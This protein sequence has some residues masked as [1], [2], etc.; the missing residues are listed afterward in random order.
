MFAAAYLANWTPH[1]VLNMGTP[2][3]S[4]VQLHDSAIIEILLKVRA[5]TQVD[6]LVGEETPGA[7]AESVG[8]QQQSPMDDSGG[9]QPAAD[10]GSRQRGE[11]AGGMAFNSM[12]T[13]P[14]NQATPA[15]TMHS[16][17]ASSALSPTRALHGSH[18]LCLYTC[19]R[20]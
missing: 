14:R 17:R 13:A 15:V 5:L 18:E 3:V 11:P 19:K 2:T 9:Q 10:D 20:H 1:W 16:T 12:G 4:I 6:V 7:T 8:G